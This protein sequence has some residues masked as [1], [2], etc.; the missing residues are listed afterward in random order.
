[1]DANEPKIVNVEPPVNDQEA[2][3]EVVEEM[4]TGVQ[5]VENMSMADVIQQAA[6]A[7]GDGLPAEKA[8]EEPA[9]EP[10]GEQSV[11]LNPFLVQQAIN[12]GLEE[13]DLDGFTDDDHLSKTLGIM[14]KHAK[15]PA[16]AGDERGDAH[17]AAPSGQAKPFVEV[18]F[19]EEDAELYPGLTK[20]L[21]TMGDALNTMHTQSM[22]RSQKVDTFIERAGESEEAGRQRWFDQQVDG[23]GEEY[24]PIFGKSAAELKDGT[25]TFIARQT[26]YDMMSDIDNGRKQRGQPPVA[27]DK[28]LRMALNA[29]TSEFNTQLTRRKVSASVKKRAEN[30]SP[31]GVQG[32]GS[33]P[34]ESREKSLRR[35]LHAKAQEYGVG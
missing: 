21:A 29:V 26:L 14:K 31:V 17:A 23:L 16:P 7:A 13:A 25:P 11:A 28:L 12:M 6:E 3:N 32:G 27:Q 5:D 22:E 9:G 15:A 18:S 10:A 19:T 2:A 30:V 35:A 34:Q 24:A 1:M 8:V 4:Q 20:A 33:A